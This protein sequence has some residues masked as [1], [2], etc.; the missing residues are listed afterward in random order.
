MAETNQNTV[1][2]EELIGPRL[3]DGSFFTADPLEHDVQGPLLPGQERLPAPEE[4]S[5]IAEEPITTAAIQPSPELQFEEAQEVPV[6]QVADLDSAITPLPEEEMT[7]KEREIQAV[8]QQIQEANLRLL[9][10]STFRAEQEQAQGLPE[11]LRTQQDLSSRLEALKKEALA[12]PLQLQQESIGRGRTAAGLR[13]LQMSRLRANAIQSLMTSSL[14]EASRGNITLAKDLVDRAVAQ[15]FDP[16]KEEINVLEKNLQLLKED[17]ET[18]V[19]ERNR[20]LKLE[21]A[22]ETRRRE[23]DKLEKDDQFIRDLALQA[24]TFGADSAILDKITSSGS[25][26]DAISI[27]GTYL[28][29]EFRIEAE[30]RA[31]D[32]NIKLRTLDLQESRLA[33]DR[34]KDLLALAAEGDLEAIKEL[35]Y[36]PNALPLSEEEVTKLEDQAALMKRDISIVQRALDNNTGLETVSGHITGVGSGDPFFKGSRQEFLADVTY[37]IR[38]LTFDKIDELGQRGIKLTPISEKEL[39][40]MGAASNQ[41]V[42]A[43]REDENGNITHFELP[44]D[45]LRELLTEVMT[46]Y[47]RAQDEIFADIHIPDDDR[48]EIRDIK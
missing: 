25:V 40:A 17:P 18:T 15:R 6:T 32:N 14:L 9:G 30:Q 35:G 27:A 47:E 26:D 34:R 5:P 33:F 8:N 20:A 39:Q 31:F 3:P 22:L 23:V 11:L 46:S 24:A 16:Y 43:A 2:E 12:I 10:E 41:L 21:D 19:Q 36:D 37:I 28:G 48:S 42:S 29:E 4:A 38:N 45:R 7:A 44:E 13:P 1:P